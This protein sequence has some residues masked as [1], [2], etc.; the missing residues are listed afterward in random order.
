MCDFSVYQYNLAEMYTSYNHLYFDD[1]LTPSDFLTI[2]WND[3]LGDT[4]GMCIKK[5]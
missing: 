1:T 4:A 5:I 2:R 3:K